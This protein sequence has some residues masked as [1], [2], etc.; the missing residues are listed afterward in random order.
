MTGPALHDLTAIKA[1]LARRIDELVQRLFGNADKDAR[2]WRLGSIH[3]EPGAS[4]AIWRFGPKQGE[5]FDF[6]AGVGGSALDLVVHA[7]TG[8]D[9]GAAIRWAADFLGMRADETPAQRAERERRDE[10]LRRERERAEAEAREKS[11]RAAKALFLHGAPIAGTPADRY[12]LG[13]AIDIRRLPRQP[14]SL[15]F[16][17]A[18]KASGE[19]RTRPCLLAA[20]S[21]E[22]GF[23]TVHR[24]FLHELPGGRVVKA[25]DAAVP[26]DWRMGPKEAKQAFGSYGGGI[27][28]IWR[29]ESGRPWARMPEGEWAAGAE[30][31]EDALSIA[32]AQP[33]LR[34]FAALGLNNL[35]KIWAPKALHGVFW[36][37]H[38][39][40]GPEAQRAYEVQM[41]RLSER[42]IVLREVWAPGDHKDF[43]EW[44]Q[45]ERDR[46]LASAQQG[47]A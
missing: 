18:V 23:M 2:H 33:D 27:I 20:V 40:D 32:I 31:I 21:G 42:G 24:H 15:R 17:P 44:L 13:R 7:Q 38:R 41:R 43:N 6:A 11:T 16:H 30:G 5:W 47:A 9:V 8:G 4:L 35:G 1:G 28:P 34:T 3:G 22:R 25:S 36:H 46:A 12:L 19:E 26:A 37:R 45:A 14:G 29:G 10:R 39:G